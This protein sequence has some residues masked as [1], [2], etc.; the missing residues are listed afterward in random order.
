V[1]AL[2]KIKKLILSETF[3]QVSGVVLILMGAI[4]VFRNR[5]L[6][7]NLFSISPIFL[8]L[9]ILC[10][11]GIYLLSGY[12]IKILLGI[13]NIPT[14]FKEWF[15]TTVIATMSNYLLPQS[16][17]AVRSS[18]FKFRRQLPLSDFLAI[19]SAEY[20]FLF[21]T[22]GFI[23]I[24]CSLFMPIDHRQKSI[25]VLI[26]G[27]FW[28]IGLVP[29]FLKKWRIRSNSWMMQRVNSVLSG[30]Q[31]IA[32]SSQAC[33]VLVLLSIIEILIFTFWY[34]LAFEAIKMD[35]PF[36]NALVLGLLMKITM[37][38]PITPGNLGIQEILLAT[39]SSL[40]G[41]GFDEGLTASLLL[42]SISLGM[43]FVL[44]FI[45]TKKL[46]GSK[47]ES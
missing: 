44:G 11:I 24:I 22:R 7:V 21:M 3:R 34:Y 45:F 38:I 19:Q 41:S 28:F 36:L 16:G 39:Y 46:L 17:I 25:F 26:F 18:Y 5:K 4:Y 8:V 27:V 23:G 29:L 6:F 42:R 37:F 2:E 1:I 12:R 40:G 20:F 35:I 47:R 14:V 15:G 43:S 30:L 33:L 32:R 9:L 13:F 10:W 31:L